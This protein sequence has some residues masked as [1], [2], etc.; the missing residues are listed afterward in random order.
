VHKRRLARIGVDA[1]LKMCFKDNFV[2]GDLHPGMTESQHLGLTVFLS[3]HASQEISMGEKSVSL[4]LLDG[5]HFKSCQF[6]ARAPTFIASFRNNPPMSEPGNILVKPGADSGLTFL[7]V[8]ITTELTDRDRGEYTPIHAH[9]LIFLMV[10]VVEPG[11]GI[12]LLRHTRRLSTLPCMKVTPCI[13]GY[14]LQ[15]DCR[16]I[17]AGNFIALF[18]AI[19]RNDGYKAGRLMIENATEQRCVVA[20]DPHKLD[21]K[22]WPTHPLLQN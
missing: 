5:A 11:S 6:H 13:Q 14:S 12:R 7:D 1:F 22:V 8:G 21:K 20:P 10:S 18:S 3:R 17:P 16:L 4:S 19:V 15:T 9:S 2:H